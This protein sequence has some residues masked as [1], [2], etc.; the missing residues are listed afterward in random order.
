LGSLYDVK[1]E[2]I[3]NGMVSTEP[4]YSVALGDEITNTVLNIKAILP[5]D[6]S[7]IRVTGSYKYKSGLEGATFSL[8]DMRDASSYE[9]FIVDVNDLY[10]NDG[11]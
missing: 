9:I 10:A 3:E 1:L 5:Y 4:S 8:D 2:Y 6:G 11:F 7:S